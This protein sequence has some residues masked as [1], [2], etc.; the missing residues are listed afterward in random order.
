VILLLQPLKCWD[1]RYEQLTAVDFLGKFKSLVAQNNLSTTS[2]IVREC[3]AD[4]QETGPRRR[5]PGKTI[6]G[7]WPWVQGDVFGKRYA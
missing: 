4:Q 6:L 1:Y 2:S 5:L 3:E 7:P